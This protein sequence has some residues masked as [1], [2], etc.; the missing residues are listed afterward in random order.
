MQPQ[1]MGQPWAPPA[2]CL[3]C[4]AIFPSP[5]L[6]T[7]GAR[8]VGV[9]ECAM[10]CPHCGGEAPIVS[11]IFSLVNNTIQVLATSQLSVEV[12]TEFFH[13][14]QE[15]VACDL[16]IQTAKA[17][18][19][20]L[21]PRLGKLFDVANWSDNARATLYASIIL[22]AMTLLAS[23][24]NNTEVHVHNEIILVDPV[25]RVAEPGTADADRAT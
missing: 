2:R 22:G 25:R 13:M 18:A 3:Q 16:P 7:P 9:L 12:L 24:L 15:T 19:E 6:I 10:T 5:I 4:G 20:A 23:A 14:M 17:Q 1:E 8:N 11:G 21:S